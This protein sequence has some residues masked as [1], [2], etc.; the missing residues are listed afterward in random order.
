M[1]FLFHVI[2][3]TLNLITMRRKT[4]FTKATKCN[5]KFISIMLKYNSQNKNS[6]HQQESSLWN[7]K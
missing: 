3:L 7:Y 2:G 1:H 5:D 6:P 4:I